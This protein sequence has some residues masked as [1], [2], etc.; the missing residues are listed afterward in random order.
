MSKWQTEVRLLARFLSS[1]VVNTFL[2]FAIIFALMA[3]GVQPLWANF[4]GYA[5][6]FFLGFVLSRNFVFRSNGR[7]V[8][9]SLRYLM[10]FAMCFVLNL[11]VLQAGLQHMA[12]I[13]AQ[14]LASAAYTASMFLLA[15]L[16]VY[17]NVS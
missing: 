3:V 11:L 14:I 13:P 2:G 17:Q 4:A 10:S 16:W 6:G 1:G 12:A 5:T 7:F 15:R 8:T 9:Q